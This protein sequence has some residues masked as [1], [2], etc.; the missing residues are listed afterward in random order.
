[1]NLQMKN[2][3]YILPLFLLSCN[4][5]YSQNSTTS[6]VKNYI[7]ARNELQYEQIRTFLADS[8]TE[9]E[10][11][12]VMSYS[13]TEYYSKFQWDSVFNPSYELIEIRKE[14]EHII[15]TI[16][17]KS[18][19]FAYLENNPLVCIKKYSFKEKKIIQIETINYINVN[20][21]V[22]QNKRDTLVKWVEN[23]HPDLSGFIYDMTRKGGEDYLKAMKL[24]LINEE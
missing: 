10:G 6:I 23:H 13:Q 19:R 16:S 24:Y 3:L 5:T 20:W 22:W 14:G 2:S 9:I 17:A 21:S 18:E 1:M 15:A 4:S 8:I 11:D 12:A 7:H